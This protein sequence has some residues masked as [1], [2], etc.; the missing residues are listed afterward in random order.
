MN[1][2]RRLSNK[3]VRNL[4][5]ARVLNNEKDPRACKLLS[6]R[7]ITLDY[8]RYW[9]CPKHFDMQQDGDLALVET[10]NQEITLV[11]CSSRD[12]GD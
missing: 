1:F 4:C 3:R 6:A 10:R 12:K 8:Q 9:L 11:D 2:V 7:F 5:Q